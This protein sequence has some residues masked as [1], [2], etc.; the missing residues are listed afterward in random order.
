MP[1]PDR[2]L[3]FATA[4]DIAAGLVPPPP[5]QNTSM[6]GTRKLTPEHVAAIMGLPADWMT[7][8]TPKETR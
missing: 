1:T 7:P 6:A 4:D 8:T 5:C 3:E 2:P